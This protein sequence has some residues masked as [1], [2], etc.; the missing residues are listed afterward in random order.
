M[1]T[2]IPGGIGGFAKGAAFAP[3]LPSPKRSP[4]LAQAGSVMARNIKA[5]AGAGWRKPGARR[6]VLRMKHGARLAA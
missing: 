1:G 2:S 3:G 5:F 6:G 4:G